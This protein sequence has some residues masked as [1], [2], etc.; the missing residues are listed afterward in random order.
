MHALDVHPPEIDRH[1][2]RHTGR[3]QVDVDVI[4]L[5]RHLA[6]LVD[7]RAQVLPRA[8]AADGAGKDVVEHQRGYRQLGHHRAHAVAHHDVHAAAH[9]HAAAFEI[10][11]A[12]REAEQHHAE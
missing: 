3:E 2:H 5:V 1:Q 9:V 4:G 12:H 11:A 6:E 8:D 7:Q 10:N